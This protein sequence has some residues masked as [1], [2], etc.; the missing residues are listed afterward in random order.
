VVT[1]EEAVPEECPK[2]ALMAWDTERRQTE[3]TRESFPRI[4][5]GPREDWQQL[6]GRKPGSNLRA[7]LL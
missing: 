6:T 7:I 5:V 1:V 4:A 2:S 3:D